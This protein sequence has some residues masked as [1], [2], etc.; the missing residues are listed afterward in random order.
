MRTKVAS[1]A[2]QKMLETMSKYNES[3]EI[4]FVW[5]NLQRDVM[6]DFEQLISK[7]S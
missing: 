4:Q 7:L 6:H 5:D 3:K 1:V 2:E